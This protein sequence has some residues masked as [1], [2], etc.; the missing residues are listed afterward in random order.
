MKRATSLCTS[1][2]ILIITLFLGF[3][4]ADP[5]WAAQK[6]KIDRLKFPALNPF[7]LPGVQKAQ[8][9]QGIKLRLIKDDRL[10]LVNLSI[11]LKG[12]DIY[13]PLEKVGLA[14][15]TARLLQIGGTKELIA[16]DLDKFLDSQGITISISSTSDY[17]QISLDCL[18]ENFDSALA[19]LSKI[20]Q[21][22]TFDQEKLEEIKN[23]QASS[24]ARRNDDPGSIMIRE[25][26]RLIYGAQSPLAAVQEYE[27]L[28][29]ISTDDIAKTYMT[30]FTPDNMLAGVV[31][32]IDI[33]E[34]QS[35]FEKHFGTWNTRAKIPPLPEIKEPAFD[36][37]VAVAEKSDINQTYLALGHLGMK[38]NLQEKA[39]I[40]VF[41]S[42]FAEGFDSRLNRR[43]RVKMGLTYGISG[44]IYPQYLYPGQVYF[45]T[46]TKTES[47][48]EAVNAIF[49]EIHTIRKD[50]VS[51]K[52]LQDAKDYFL[53][54]H[55]FN[56]STPEKILQRSLI[57]EFY[58]EDEGADKKFIEDVKK[59][60]AQDVLDAAQTYL[61]PDKMS[62]LLVGNEEKIKASG[63]LAALG[64]VQEW[65]ISIKPPA[66]K[67][68]IPPATPGM[69][70]KGQEILSSLLKTSY[71][72]YNSLKSLE[73][74]KDS[75]LTMGNQT[76]DMG[77]KTIALYP[78]K[79]YSEISI[80]GGM[81]KME[82]II[83]GKKGVL[84]QAGKE[85][86]LP[87]EEIEKNLFGD[88]YDVFSPS[89]KGKY[90]F[91]YLEEEK[92][93]GKTYDVI[94]IF[95]SRNHWVKFFIN[96]ETLLIEVE[97]KLANLP[98]QSGIAR[99]VYSD[100]QAIKGI[101]FAFKSQAYVKDK[102]VMEE[103]V[104]KIEVN[105]GV[106]MNLFKIE[107]NK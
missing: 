31:G 30:F 86:P 22:P 21:Q 60:T 102:I 72:G 63:D 100:F 26:A 12:G 75:K 81:M 25:I 69:L 35:L 61:H 52:E 46:F 88:L 39:K 57:N 15:I 6:R 9:P 104:K 90:S 8:T 55:V 77:S 32:P 38:E 66:L 36:F 103:S 56:Y 58:G 53:N 98:G 74:V 41:N 44:G 62:I 48:L 18:R 80:M 92:L 11:L 93:D 97:E 28:D 10:P 51:E 43:I 68:K 54:S 84:K 27:H 37:K 14:D 49:D 3:S 106:D 64:K 65:D 79:F 95:D 45:W 24:I 91:Q 107:G 20:L 94:Y 71:Q 82:Y 85:I 78:D 19:I 76:I 2:I 5:A 47:T 59:V 96:R 67:E 40:K 83:D 105:P 70:A 7:Q 23:Q 33:Q 73:V 89:E 34:L 101:P 29:N 87:A 17:F 1:L 16:E 13:D 50:L 99:T 42:I 4:G